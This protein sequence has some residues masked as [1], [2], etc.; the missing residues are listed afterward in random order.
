MSKTNLAVSFLFS[1]LLLL[2]GCTTTEGLYGLN[3][4]GSNVVFVLDLSGS[5]EGN[6]EEVLWKRE[7]KGIVDKAARAGAR[8]VDRRLPIPGVGIGKEIYRYLNSKASQRLTLLSGAKRELHSTLKDFS[9]NTHFT[10]LTFS[11]NVTHWKTE[12]LP[13]TEENIRTAS[14]FLDELKALGGTSIGK[15]LKT[16]LAVKNVDE[17]FLVTDGAPTD[18]SPSRILKKIRQL[19]T[20][21]HVRINAIGIG[22]GQNVDFLTSLA[23]ENNGIFVQKM[24]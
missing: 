18:E 16:A 10:I 24:G 12:L 11:D 4:T 13:A 19:N 5:M 15:A 23:N 1:L 21:G 14:A 6:Q 7:T 20:A 9:P 3:V 8:E 2:G 17:I 22:E